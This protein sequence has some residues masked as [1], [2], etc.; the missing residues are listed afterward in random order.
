MPHPDPA[1]RAVQQV[2]H[3]TLLFGAAAHDLVD[4]LT[5]GEGQ[6]QRLYL[7]TLLQFAQSRQAT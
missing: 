5:I 3:G 4:H 2:Q 6:H 7:R 1:G